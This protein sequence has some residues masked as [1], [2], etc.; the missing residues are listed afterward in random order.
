MPR[1]SRVG[2]PGVRLYGRRHSQYRRLRRDHVFPSG[3]IWRLR[4]GRRG[5]AEG[6]QLPRSGFRGPV[7]GEADGGG[8]GR[9]GRNCARP[10]V[11][12]EPVRDCWL[13]LCNRRSCRNMAPNLRWV[14]AG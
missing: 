1:I 14:A 8:K 7:G 5:G 9:G 12:L 4:R 11:S 13:L 3:S 6:A 10:L 2:D